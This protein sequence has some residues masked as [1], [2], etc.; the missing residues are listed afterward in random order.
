[1]LSTMMMATRADVFSSSVLTLRLSESV[2]SSDL[3]LSSNS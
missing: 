2:S 3:T 1:M